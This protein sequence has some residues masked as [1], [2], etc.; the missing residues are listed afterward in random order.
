MSDRSYL[1][2][3]RYLCY[4]VMVALNA[5]GFP[6]LFTGFLALLQ[7]FELARHFVMNGWRD[8]ISCQFLEARKALL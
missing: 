4:P 5:P 2:Y 8:E 6:C 3:P 1:C 7:F